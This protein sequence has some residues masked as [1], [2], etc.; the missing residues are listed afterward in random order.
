MVLFFDSHPVQ[1]KAPVYQRLQQLRP[2]SF[3]VVYATDLTARGHHDREFGQSFA[4]DQP[5]LEGYPHLVLNNERGIPL[6]GFRSLT[7]KGIHDLLQKERP[8]AVVI[9]QFIYE[10]DL[11]TYLS[12]LRLNIPIW[13]R[14]ETQDEALVRPA[15]KE[16][17]R[18]LFYRLAYRQVSHAFYFGNKGGQ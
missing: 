13:I 14:Q 6:T 7:G 5:L 11:V 2:G 18:G 1:Y 4:W 8:D 10:F 16:T 17:L 9:S 15:W 3:K 12:C